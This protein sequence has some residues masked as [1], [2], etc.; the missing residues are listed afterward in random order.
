MSAF[1]LYIPSVYANITAPMISETFHRMNV[2]RVKHVELVSQ[3]AKNGPRQNKAYIFFEALYQSDLAMNIQHN[4]STN[5]TTKL[6][7]GRS[8]HVFW[9]LLNSK[10]QYDGSS[11]N[12]EYVEPDFTE[13]EIEFVEQE[14]ERQRKE[15]EEVVDTSFVSAD[16]ANTL[17]QEMY[18][19]RCVNA[20]LQTNYMSV[21]NNHLVLNDKMNKWTELGMNN[22][23]TRLCNAIQRENRREDGEEDEEIPV[24]AVN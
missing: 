12:G 3:N 17:E 9:V 10:R 11:N 15:E 19:L 20:Q 7:Y 24:V 16:Y 5:L 21:F 18:K 4:V 14:L 2:G 23:G 8:E 13:E 6:P 22:Q 1:S